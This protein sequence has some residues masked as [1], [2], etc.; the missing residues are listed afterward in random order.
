MPVVFL[1]S[2]FAEKEP[3]FSPDGRWLAYQSNETGRNEI[4]VRPF[5]GHG[6]GWRYFDRRRHLSN[7]VARAT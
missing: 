5:R 1:N 7:L 3:N 2:P 6:E 4:Y